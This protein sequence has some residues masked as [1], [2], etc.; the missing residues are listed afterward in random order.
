MKHQ[1][2]SSP[3]PR[4]GC[5]SRASSQAREPEDLL[6]QHV[7]YW[8]RHN[9]FEAQRRTVRRQCP[10][11]YDID[12]H[13]VQIEWQYGA[14]PGQ[15][16]HLVVV[17]GPLRQPF[18]DY[19]DMNEAN[20]EWYDTHTIE[21]TS[22]LHHV[23][24][25]RRMTFDD[26]HKKYSRLE[27]MKVAKEQASL[28]EKAAD[29]TRDGKQVPD[30]LVRKYNKALRQKLRS[31][32]AKD[33]SPRAP[34]QRGEA[35]GE[36]AGAAKPEPAPAPQAVP[37]LACPPPVMAL[38]AHRGISLNGLPSYMPAQTSASAA[39]AGISRSWSGTNMPSSTVT[40][41]PNFLAIPGVALPAPVGQV[42]GT[43]P[44]ASVCLCPQGST[45]QPQPH[46][47]VTVTAVPMG[48][49]R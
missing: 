21:K 34:R 42:A 30:D 39:F 25:E 27:A 48:Y 40:T 43:S 11:V 49:Y 44:M 38:M 26:T 23:P 33:D 13:Q 16:G 2:S 10:G 37:E 20:A 8:L 47:A 1:T 36:A 17:D 5:P 12:G 22:A 7:Q 3:S 9:P 6:D 29:Y 24:K 19:M 4:A 14:E 45:A 28:R 35:T 18:A 15:H 31:G 46:S 41:A 32:R